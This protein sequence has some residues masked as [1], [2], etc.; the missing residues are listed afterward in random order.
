MNGGTQYLGIPTPGSPNHKIVPRLRLR[1]NGLDGSSLLA[2]CAALFAAWLVVLPSGA[3][4]SSSNPSGQSRRWPLSLPVVAATNVINPSTRAVRLFLASDA[5]SRSNAAA[6]LNALRAS[7]AQWQNIPGTS[8]R[9]EEAGLV[10]PGT[11]VNTSDGTNAVFWAKNGTLVNGGF[12]D[13]SGTL[14]VTFPRFSPDNLLLEA[15]IVLNGVQFT[16]FTDFNAANSVDQFVEGTMLHEIGHF[17]G[18]D[19]SPVGGATMLARGATG[20]NTQAGLSSDEIAAARFLYPQASPLNGLSALQGQVA[21]NGIGVFGACVV[22]ED[23]SGNVVSGTVTRPDGRYELPCLNPGAYEVRVSP[24]DPPASAPLAR[25]VSGP[26]I[27]P[28][29]ANAETSFHPP[30]PK[31]ITLVAGAAMEL[32]FAVSKGSPRFRISRIRPTGRASDE[33]SAVNSPATIRPGESNLVVGVYSPDFPANGAVLRITGDGLSLGPDT[34]VPDAFPGS[35]PALHLLSV[36]IHASAHATPG[37]RSFVVQHGTN[38]AYAHGFLEVLPAVPDYNFDGLDDRFQRRHF[39]L[40]TTENAAPNAD[41]DGDG[42]DN[43]SE[44]AAGTGPSDRRSLLR[45]ERVNPTP[46]GAA[47]TWQSVPGRRYEL[48]VRKDLDLGTWTPIGGAVM[49]TGATTQILDGSAPNSLR[50]Y[51]VLVLP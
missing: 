40:F 43:A 30:A 3:F 16:W 5:Y 28:S 37:L 8:L 50:F 11:D 13:I 48:F 18:L 39:P 42:F 14:S 26:D 29:Y 49:A 33:L 6:E 44:H 21:A 20:V 7:F 12:D 4:V 47:V 23:A 24:L 46:L 31:A 36:T 35:R 27:A 41:P 10:A 15:D 19:H 22:A 2:R 51:R 9:F 25:L 1:M 32:D 38:A 45:I 34:F 17:I